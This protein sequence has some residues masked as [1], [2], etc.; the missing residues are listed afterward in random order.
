MLRFDMANRVSFFFCEDSSTEEED[1]E[2]ADQYVMTR[3]HMALVL[4]TVKCSRG[5][6]YGSYSSCFGI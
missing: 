1:V 6:I 3:P 5:K 4:S 2:I